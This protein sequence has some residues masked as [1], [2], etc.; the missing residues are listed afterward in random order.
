MALKLYNYGNLISVAYKTA[1]FQVFYSSISEWW[2]TIL[3]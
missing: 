3:L 1:Q 2:Q